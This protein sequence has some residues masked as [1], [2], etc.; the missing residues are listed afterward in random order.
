MG[1]RIMRARVTAIHLAAPLA[2]ALALGMTSARA[3]SVSPL[4]VEIRP[5]ERARLER[6]AEAA[7][8]ATR[9][10][11]EPF[12]ARR[13]IFEYLL[14][15]PEFAT[16]VTRTLRLARYRIWRTSD[17]M[18]LDDGWGAT[19]HFSVVH[20]VAG[21]RVM[22]ARGAYRQTVLPTINGEAVAMIEY[23]ITPAGDGRDL[24]HATVSGFVKLDSGILALATKIV[25]P[26]AQRK[27]DLEARRLMRTFAR[28]SRAIEDNPADLYERLRQRPDVPARELQEFGRLL[29][30]R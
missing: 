1:A 20:A 13:E 5:D 28:V 29:N 21:R 27:A 18:F 30:L 3:A 8:V 23:E 11:T 26:I 2:I 16:H 14:D 10:A 6:V 7:S 12:L 24:V 9:V 22:Y 25:G 4:P 15:H 17:G 19:G